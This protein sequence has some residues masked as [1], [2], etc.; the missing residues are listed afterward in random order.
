ML[1]GRI[2]LVL[3]RR[4]GEPDGRLWTLTP[5]GDLP[6]DVITLQFVGRPPVGAGFE[7]TGCLFPLPVSACGFL[8][9]LPLVV[10]DLF[11][12]VPDFLVCL[13]VLM[14]FCGQLWFR[15]ASERRQLRVPL[16]CYP[17]RGSLSVLSDSLRPH[18]LYSPW[19]SPGQNSRVGSRSLL[20]G[21][22][23]TQGLN[24]GLPRCRQILYQLS[25]QGRPYV[26]LATP[27]KYFFWFVFLIVF[28]LFAYLFFNS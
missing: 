1:W 22:F 27:K 7:D 14:A 11:W 12:W 15:R 9:F 19:N 10:R 20:Q 18:G 24:P 25:H 3:D 2:F 16:L 28:Y 8:W 17:E 21:I 26:I 23:P 4:A 6:E 13:F 5:V